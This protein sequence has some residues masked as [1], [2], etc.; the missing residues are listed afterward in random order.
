MLV[1]RTDSNTNSLM[2]L[3]GHKD[4]DMKKDARA[5]NGMLSMTHGFL[6]RKNAQIHPHRVAI[7][8]VDN[9]KRCT[10]Q[11]L[12]R[13]VNRL[14]NGLQHIGITKGDKVALLMKDRMECVELV[15]ALNKIGA[16]WA[17]CNY[18]YVADEVQFQVDH[19]DSIA[20]VFEE[21]YRDIIE[22][23]RFRLP[24]IRDNRFIVIGGNTSPEYMLYEDLSS[25][26]SDSEPDIMINDTDP[27]GLVYTSG[28]TGGSKG[29]VVTAHTFIGWAMVPVI[30]NGF[31]WEDRVLN[32]YPMFHMG[33][34][35]ISVACLIAGATNYIFGKFDPYKFLTLIQDEKITC[36][37]TVPTL[38]NAITKLPESEVRRFDLSSLARLGTSGAPFL[39]DTKE[40]VLNYWPHVDL[41]SWYSATEAFY[42]ML[43]PHDQKRKVRC[44]GPAAFG[45]EI[46]ILD[47]KGQD[48]TQGD[49]GLIYG[50]GISIFDGYYKNPEATKRGFRGEWFTCEDMGYLDE[51]G[52]LYV[53]DRKK[54]MILSGGENISSVEIE[55]VLLG[56]P[57]I[58]EVAVVGIPDEVFGERVHA[59]VSLK[60]GCATT[61]EEIIEW[62]RNRMAGYKRPRSAEVCL[63]GLPKSPVGK[64]LKR[65]IRDQYWQDKTIKI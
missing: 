30:E 57:K 60:P 46:K 37:V 55:N 43:L 44:V 11:E 49:V 62:C 40:M 19:S 17:P 22:A 51:E 18:R 36:S 6:L 61:S 1:A 12:N 45:M 3:E 27:C 2:V 56:H 26:S 33:G 48:V 20:I 8:D 65:V 21:E 63:S 58:L 24:K 5:I 25:R 9:N 64:I 23:I 59:V 54:D 38:L 35:V 14:A 29:A 42:S 4:S 32:P 53:V 31:R 41:Y 15:Y 7:V 34:T 16:V 10:Y 13:R 52:Y 47:E 28:T 39:E 50:R